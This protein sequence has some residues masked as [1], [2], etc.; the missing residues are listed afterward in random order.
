MADDLTE[1]RGTIERVLC[2]VVVTIVLVAIVYSAAI[3]LA[4]Y[5]K[6]GV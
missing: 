1:R 2:I 3:A 4:N 6:I 5:D